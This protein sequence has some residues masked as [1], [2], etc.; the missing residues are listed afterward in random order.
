[1]PL[2]IQTAGTHGS[3]R[4]HIRGANAP[5]NAIIINARKLPNPY[6][7]L[8]TDPKMSHVEHVQAF[9]REKCPDKVDKL[10]ATGCKAIRNNQPVVVVCLY[11]RDRSKAIAQLIGDNFDSN[12]VYY[13]HRED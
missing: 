3:R 6:G 12:E 13:E 10:V 9:L 5:S 7:E 2:M 8:G 11:G 4:K 1:M